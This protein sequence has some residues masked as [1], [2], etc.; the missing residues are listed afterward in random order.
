MIY[1]VHT[2][3]GLAA[4]CPAPG[5]LAQLFGRLA[6]GDSQWL[7]RWEAGSRLAS[8]GGTVLAG[9]PGA[10][11]WLLCHDGTVDFRCFGIFGP[12]TPADDAL[13]ALVADEAVRC[14]RAVTDLNFTR[15]HS[16]FRSRLTLD[17]GGH[18]GTARGVEPAAHNDPFGGIF[19]FAGRLGEEHSFA[20]TAP[21]P[22]QYDIF[23]VP[24]GEAFPLYSWWQVSIENQGG[25]EEKEIDKL[26]QVTERIDSTHVRV[27]YKLG[28][29]LAAGRQMT[30]R[31]VQP[32]EQVHL[33]NFDFYGNEGGEA[34]GAH[35]IALEYAV[36]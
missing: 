30:W 36:R 8:N 19:H 22:E 18:R 2:A 24:G 13:D 28:W 20:L 26:L 33:Q 32:V 11:R 6:P 16:F 23:E 34:V 29:P 27:N 25:R 35:P 10:G 5:D 21:L 14:I 4:L 7:Y 15:R 17:F 3:A 1:S 12:E 31:A 9:A